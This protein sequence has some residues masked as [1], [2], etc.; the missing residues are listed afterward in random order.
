[1]A[2]DTKQD[3]EQEESSAQSDDNV[4][5]AVPESE[6]KFKDLLREALEAPGAEKIPLDVRDI[7]LEEIGEGANVRPT[8][9]GI[10]NLAETMHLQGQLQ[11]CVVRPSPENNEHGRP[12]ELVC[13]FRRYR[14]AL[15]L[16][17]KEIEGWE[18]L[19]CEVREIPDS[20][21]IRQTIVENFQREDLSPVAEARAM[22]QL[23]QS[24]E[25]ELS[26]VEV[27]RELG[28]DPSHVSH[29]LKL[30]K[31]ALPE[32]ELLPEKEAD[33]DPKGDPKGD[34]KSD[35]Q[36]EDSQEKAPPKGKKAKKP[37]DIL[38]MVDRGEIQA[39]T[40][41]VITSLEDRDQ[42]EKLA[43]LAKRGQW[44]TKK[45]AQWARDVKENVVKDGDD[46]ELGPVAMIEIED[47][48]ELPFLRP[49]PDISDEEIERL[50]LYITLRNGMDREM[51][52]YLA[53]KLDAPY[54]GLW[55]YVA[56]LSIADVRALQ[57][58]LALR[59]IAAA[60][61]W[62]SLEPQLKEDLGLPEEAPEEDRKIAEELL[63]LLDK[64]GA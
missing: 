22:Q 13:G 52:E 59:Y 42:Q 30:L 1:M 28:C 43:T 5:K 6:K 26:N 47:V 48:V 54:E 62:F 27:A 40:A 21:R 50:A 58:R 64:D 35:A 45:A 7:P 23:K 11:P 33:G 41:E 19:R 24:A 51:L 31:L 49:R 20:R 61:R 60:H 18:T 63:G 37:V 17:E 12:Y 39:S 9:H 55:G 15:F 44:S 25:P 57:R 46:E 36:G 38:E 8:Y 32:K 34:S 4:K 14:A 29:R 2:E 3:T 10:E 16:Q 56:S 53:E